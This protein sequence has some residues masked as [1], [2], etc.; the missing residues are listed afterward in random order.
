MIYK[1]PLLE[2]CFELPIWWRLISLKI[3]SAKIEWS[4]GYGVL[5]A[6]PSE[7]DMDVPMILYVTRISCRR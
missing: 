1:D 7:L 4:I 5:I 3:Q 6:K 2:R